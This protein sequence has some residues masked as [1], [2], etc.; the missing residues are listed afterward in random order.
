MTPLEK[1]R[2]LAA[3]KKAA[4][5]KE[6]VTENTEANLEARMKLAQEAI[7][8]ESQKIPSSTTQEQVQTVAEVQGAESLSS[9]SE[10]N[11]PVEESE[12]TEVQQVQ[13]TAVVELP[14]QVTSSSDDPLGMELSEEA[15]IGLAAAQYYAD[16]HPLVMELAEL[17]DA[18]NKNIPD[19]RLQ[20]RNI[21]TK[22]RQDPA[23]VTAMTDEEIGIVVKGLITHA[24]AEIVAPKAVKAAKSAAKKIVSADDL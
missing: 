23:I 24:N 4:E 10:G 8:N 7:V 20:L 14:V 3:A 19:F 15:R 16:A 17:E 11:A 12:G 18:L 21:H 2:A 13:G 22:L 6:L 9:G 5:V 1:L